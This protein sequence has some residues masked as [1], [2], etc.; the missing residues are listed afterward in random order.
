MKKLALLLAL[1]STPAAWAQYG[2]I[3]F[4]GGQTLFTNNGLGTLATIGGSKD[5]VKLKDGFRFGFRVAFN[6]DSYFGHEIQYA[7]SRRNCRSPTR[8]SKGWPCIPVATTI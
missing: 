7:Y 3:W 5:D 6:G 8:D 1:A 2:E 4:S